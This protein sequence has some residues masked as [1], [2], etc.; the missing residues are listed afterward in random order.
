MIAGFD[1]QPFAHEG[2]N[3]TVY[4][5]GAGPGIVL[6][7]ELPGL[8]EACIRLARKLV[9]ASYRVYMPLLFGEAGKSAVLRNTKH[10]CISREFKVFAAN[11]TSPIVNWLRAV[12][13]LAHRECG[14]PGVGAIGM[15]LTGNFV[16]SLMADE[17]MLAPVSCQPS[18]PFHMGGR[19]RSA[20]AVDPEELEKAKLRA[21]NGQKLLCFRFSNDFMSPEAR[22]KRL[23]REFGDAFDGTRIDSS[24]GNEHHIKPRSHAV[25]TKDFVDREGHPTRAALEKV[26]SFFGERLVQPS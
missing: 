11:E 5:S 15:C 20:L 9:D 8:T 22:F 17:H 3:H 23:E 19:R 1:Q 4:T 13:A 26:L 16:I 10:V 25:L 14:G 2:I 12:C 6:I 7:H 18:L 21:R 24:R